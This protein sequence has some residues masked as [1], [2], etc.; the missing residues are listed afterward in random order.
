MPAG[1]P[2]PG[3]VGQVIVKHYPACREA[4]V[5]A[6]AV[7]QSAGTDGMFMSLFHHIQSNNIP[8]TAPVEITWSP[9]GTTQPATPVAMAFIYKT[10][11]TGTP[12]TASAE[13]TGGVRVIDIP[14]QTVLSIGIRGGYE[15]DNFEAALGQ[16]DQYLK[17]RASAYTRAGPP[18][19]LGYNSPFVPPFMRFGEVQ[20]PV[21][22]R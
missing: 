15:K 18:R 2:P 7:T 9:P 12:T 14:A 3:P 17:S 22:V 10:P 20:I 21:T 5:D 19:Y 1:F 6:D 16:L 4:R 13:T 8:M 11:D